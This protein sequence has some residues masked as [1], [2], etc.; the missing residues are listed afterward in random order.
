MN[1]HG[2][3]R[4]Q[5]WC[6]VGFMAMVC[7]MAIAVFLGDGENRKVAIAGTTALLLSPF[8]FVPPFFLL[9]RH[10]RPDSGRPFHETNFLVELGIYRVV[11]HPQ[12]LG[13][14]LL[15]A[16]F[17]ARSQ[18]VA[19]IVPAVVAVAGMHGQAA[20]EESFCR[21]RFGDEFDGYARRVPMYNVLLGVFRLIEKRT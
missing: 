2:G 14:M 12:Y 19:A 21:S 1:D 16:G 11:R 13:Y 3:E 20:A 10:G 8:F 17:A 7:V 4:P 18:H 15:I 6:W 9:K 5:S